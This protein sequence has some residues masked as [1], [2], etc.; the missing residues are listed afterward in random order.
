MKAKIFYLYLKGKYNGRNNGEIQLH[1]SE[2]HGQQG[3]SCKSS[4]YGAAHE[5]EKAGWITRTDRGGLYKN[6]NVY[7]L[8]GTYDGMLTRD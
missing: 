3:F 8:T 7:E 2:L 6:P 5:L 4:F 1:Y